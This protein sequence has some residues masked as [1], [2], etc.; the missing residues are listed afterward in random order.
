MK[1]PAKIRRP[2]TEKVLACR[3]DALL[4]V[5]PTSLAVGASP[6][7]FIPNRRTPALRSGLRYLHAWGNVRSRK[8]VGE[9]E[10]VHPPFGGGYEAGRQQDELRLHL[11]K[12]IDELPQQGILQGTPAEPTI[13]IFPQ[14]EGESN[15]TRVHIIRRGPR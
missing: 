10:D 8:G 13:R 2:S 7:R 15:V 9:H 6:S 5:R 1:D 3:L 12:D 4:P 11:A 14:D